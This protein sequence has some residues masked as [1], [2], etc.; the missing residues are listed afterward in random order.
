MK[1][2]LAYEF[3]SFIRVCACACAHVWASGQMCTCG[4]HRTTQVLSAWMPSTTP[5][6]SSQQLIPL[7]RGERTSFLPLYVH[8]HGE[9][10]PSDSVADGI[11]SCFSS[12]GLSANWMKFSLSYWLFGSPLLGKP[13]HFV[14]Q[15][16]SVCIF[17]DRRIFFMYPEY[18]YFIVAMAN[19][20]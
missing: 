1:F 15:L 2:S 8:Y 11:T 7:G 12:R 3:Y 20:L 19:I 10:K 4:G 16:S 6:H 17:V 9:M 13:Q 18:W 5:S 14:C